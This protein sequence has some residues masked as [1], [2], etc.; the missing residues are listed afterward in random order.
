LVN[1]RLLLTKVFSYP[2]IDFHMPSQRLAVGTEEGAVIMYDLKTAS[3]LYVLEGFRSRL[4]GCSFSP[5]GRRL[6]TVSLGECLAMVWKVG[7]SFTS[8]FMPGAPP[9]QGTSG[10]QPFKTF[11]FNVAQEG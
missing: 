7:S 8:F 3:R 5:D 9:R 4:S 1:D 6:I 11:P 10:S 2:S